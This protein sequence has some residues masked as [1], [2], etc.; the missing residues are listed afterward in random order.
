MISIYL[1]MEFSGGKV[2]ISLCLIMECSKKSHDFLMSDYGIFDKKSHDFPMSE[3][4]MFEKKDILDI[5]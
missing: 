1:S 4:G 3:Y 5:F 2:M